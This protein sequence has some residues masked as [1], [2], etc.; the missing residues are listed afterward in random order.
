MKRFVLIVG[1]AFLAGCSREAKEDARK[2]I[3][4]G[5]GKSQ[6]ETYQQLRK[7]IRSVTEEHEKQLKEE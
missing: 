5:T 3:D 4:Y 1:V 2:V 7:Q 6:V